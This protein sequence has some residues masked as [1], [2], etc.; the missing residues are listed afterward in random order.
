MEVH[1]VQMFPTP[2][3]D[4]FRLDAGREGE[5][6]GL[7]EYVMGIHSRNGTRLGIIPSVFTP[8]REGIP[9]KQ[10]SLNSI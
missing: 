4:R 2:R 8:K 7:V 5:K 9:R 1:P 10:I 6:V 3:L